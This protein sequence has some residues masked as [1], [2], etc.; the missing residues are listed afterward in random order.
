MGHWFDFNMG[1]ITVIWHIN[2]SSLLAFAIFITFRQYISYFAY[3]KTTFWLN[4]NT[5]AV[6]MNRLHYL[7]CLITREVFEPS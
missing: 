6:F 7:R 1:F 5:F 2:N 3:G 4:F